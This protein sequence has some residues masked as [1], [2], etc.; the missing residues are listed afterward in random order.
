MRA[1]FHAELGELITDLARMVRLAGQT[2]TNAA[3]ALH[4]LDLALAGVAIA[5]CDQ[6]TASLDDTE[7]RCVALL[8][9][10]PLVAGD[11]RVVVAAVHAVGHLKRMANLARHIAIIPRL[12]H[13]NP[14]MSSPVRPVLARMSLLA[15]QLA[16]DAA[17]AIEHWDPL[18]GDWLAEADEEVDTLR[19]HLFS[20]LFAED[21]SYGVEPAVNAVLIGRY[22]ERFA[23][24]AVAIARRVCYPSIGRISEPDDPALTSRGQPLAHHDAPSS[25]SQRVAAT[26]LSRPNHPSTGRLKLLAGSYGVEA[27][28]RQQG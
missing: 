5:K 8:M 20:I 26:P 6:M 22:Y 3:I 19:R 7:Q 14:M 11:L 17:T 15:S 28:K 13:P 4:Q 1:T 16:G 18:S 27:R 10:Q 21:W 9:Q 25:D 24:H 2:M 12:K 23:D